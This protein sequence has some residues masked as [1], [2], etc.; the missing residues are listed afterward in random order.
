MNIIIYKMHPAPEVYDFAVC[1]WTF[2][3]MHSVFV[4]ITNK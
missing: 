1:A 3:A 2:W 4:C